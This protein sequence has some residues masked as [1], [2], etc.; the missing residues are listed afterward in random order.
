MLRQTMRALLAGHGGRA[1]RVADG[2]MNDVFPSRDYS[3]VFRN[4]CL[5][6]RLERYRI[7]SQ[8]L[9]LMEVRDEISKL[10]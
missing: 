9:T 5:R 10:A 7:R 8:M 3:T 2:S 1:M 4:I 6:G